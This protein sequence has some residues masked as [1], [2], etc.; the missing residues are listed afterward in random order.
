MNDD[1]GVMVFTEQREGEV[2]PVSYELLGKGR[3][4][5]DRLGVPLSAVLLGNQMQAEVG[6]LVYYG[7]DK[8][9]WYDHP[10]F[11]D[12]DLLNYKHNI[13]KLVR[14]VKPE[15]FLLGATHWGRSLGPRIA[16]ALDTGLTADCTGLGIDEDGG[17]IQI[18][19]AF[20]GNVLAQIKTRT[21]PQPL[22]A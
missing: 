6:E 19:P 5:A 17:L 18:R 15:I 21:R 8:V 11:Q 22:K 14:E 2:H 12:L 9:F 1:K 10:I 13:V 7:A 3:E 16:V 20:S 4:I